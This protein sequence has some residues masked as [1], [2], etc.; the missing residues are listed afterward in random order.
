MFFL[1]FLNEI[2]LIKYFVFYIVF[3]CLKT[4]FDFI[5]L[6]ILFAKI[7]VYD[8]FEMFHMFLQ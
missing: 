7:M 6:N 1:L 4:K 8:H 5:S 2:Y 3:S